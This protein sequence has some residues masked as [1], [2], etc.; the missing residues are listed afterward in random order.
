MPKFVAMGMIFFDSDKAGQAE[1]WAIDLAQ[2]LQDHTK[3]IAVNATSVA[4]GTAGERTS[5]FGAF[6]IN[7]DGTLTEVS[8]W[9]LDAIDTVKEGKPPKSGTKLTLENTTPWASGKAYPAGYNVSHNKKFWRSMIDN[10]LVE[11]VKSVEQW[12]E[13]STT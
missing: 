8:S 4:V 6:R 1:Q 13:V 3:T 7:D 12:A 5:H 2:S 10:N 11:P 9:H